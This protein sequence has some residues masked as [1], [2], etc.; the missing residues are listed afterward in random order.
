MR[1][2]RSEQNESAAP[3]EAEVAR[4]FRHFACGPRLCEKSHRCYDSAR[5][6][7]S[8]SDGCQASWKGLIGA[9]AVCSQPNLKTMW[10][11]TIWFAR[12]TLSWM[13]LILASLALVGLRRWKE[14]GPAIIRRRCSRYT[15]MAISI[16]SHRAVA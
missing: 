10:P 15:F 11:R 9:K 3:Q 8:G 13:V 2:S 12:L 4:G 6:S 14:G 16:A 5:E 1:K 7:A